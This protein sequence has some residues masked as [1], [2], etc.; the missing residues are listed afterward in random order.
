MLDTLWEGDLQTR[1]DLKHSASAY[2][3]KGLPSSAKNNTINQTTNSLGLS[4]D[5]ADPVTLYFYHDQYSYD[6]DPKQAA[7][8]LMRTAPRRSSNTRTS[9]L[10]FADASNNLGITWRAMD[11]LTLDIS[12]SKTTTQ[13]DQVQK[14]RRLGI[15]YQVTDRLSLTASVTFATSTAVVTKQPV[16]PNIP[17][18]TVPAGT[19]VLPATN[20]RYAELSLGWSF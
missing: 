6:R 18:L 13:L 4:Q 17:A 5:L 2:Q 9:L 1:L 16:F 8:Y 12:T 14:S 11:V 7:Q 15:D 10:S 19:V 3:F 20:D